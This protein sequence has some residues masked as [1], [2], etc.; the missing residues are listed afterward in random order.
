MSFHIGL[1]FLHSLFSSRSFSGAC[2]CGCHIPTWLSK[3]DA[4]STTQI[5]S[6]HHKT[7]VYVE[8][9]DQKREN[10]DSEI[11]PNPWNVAECV[12]LTHL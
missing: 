3:I 11:C 5:A 8:K 10:D 2:A 9:R 1:L 6:C 4:T 12:F 7:V